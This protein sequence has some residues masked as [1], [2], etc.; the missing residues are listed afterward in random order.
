MVGV[1]DIF[2]EP[3][4]LDKQMFPSEP[5]SFPS[6]RLSEYS[7]QPMGSSLMGFRPEISQSDTMVVHQ[8]RPK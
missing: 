2:P 8:Q 4:S 7:D 5:N 3:G 6:H 1:Q